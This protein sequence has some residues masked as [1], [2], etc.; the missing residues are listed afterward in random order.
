MFD[1]KYIHLFFLITFLILVLFIFINFFKNNLDE[2]NTSFNNIKDDE[3]I[4]YN[5][6][7]IKNVNYF[8]KDNSG[9]EYTVNADEG[10][11]DFSNKDIIYL[12]NIN[13]SIKLSNSDNITIFSKFGKYN[14]LNYD[15]IFSKNVHITYKDIEIYGDYLDFSIENNQMI[16]SKNVTLINSTNILKAD[17]VEMNI[18]NR[19]TKIY[20]YEKDKKVLFKSKN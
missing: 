14:I 11:I 16:I 3:K 15:T 12:K 19:D 7:V 8:T 9:N 5:S 10:E 13:S 20:M 2:K 18:K 1:K 17:V 4:I 6:N